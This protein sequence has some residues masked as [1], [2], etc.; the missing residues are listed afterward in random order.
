MTSASLY[1]SIDAETG[2]NGLHPPTASRKT[3]GIA[4]IALHQKNVSAGLLYKNS[5]RMNFFI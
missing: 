5:E 1:T 2:S 4:I 3:P